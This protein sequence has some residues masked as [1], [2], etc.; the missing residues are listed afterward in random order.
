MGKIA[1]A[2]GITIIKIGARVAGGKFYPG[3]QNKDLGAFRKFG[4]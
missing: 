2:A 4:K 3:K 1:L